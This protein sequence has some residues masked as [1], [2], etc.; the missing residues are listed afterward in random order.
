MKNKTFQSY[1]FRF[2]EVAPSKKDILEFIKSGNMD[3]CHLM[4]QII[5]D[6]LQFLSDC[7]NQI[8]GGYAIKEVSS[9]SVKEGKIWIEGV[10]LEVGIQIAT[11]LKGA[12]YAALFLCT[13]GEIFTTMTKKYNKKGDYL[14][15]YIVDTIGSLT[16]ENAMDRIQQQ[17]AQSLSDNHLKISNRYSPGYCNWTLI[18]QYDL[19]KL[20]GDNPIGVNLTDSALMIPIKSVSGVIG[21]GYQVKK[22]A[23][24]CGICNNK[25]CIY[26]EILK[27]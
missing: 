9:L 26:R 16:V 15:A 5:D 6:L 8:K 27:K 14:E 25:T 22:R 13:A 19:F 18:G 10:L 1:C 23:Y 21:I 2:K 20:I 17:L 3:E 7:N 4:N 12:S 24:G 11:Y